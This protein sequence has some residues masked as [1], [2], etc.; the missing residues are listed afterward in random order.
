[1]RPAEPMNLVG[2][3][4]KAT[5]TFGYQPRTRFRELVRIMVEHDLAQIRSNPSA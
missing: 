3:H 5:R 2:D 1:M 4:S